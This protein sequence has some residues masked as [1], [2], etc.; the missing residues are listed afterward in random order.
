MKHIKHSSS[1][2]KY[3]NLQTTVHIQRK[4]PFV[5]A[6]K[7]VSKQL[8]QLSAKQPNVSYITV[9]GMGAAIEKTMALGVHFQAQG[10]VD[11]LTKTITVMDEFEEDDDSTF[12]KRVISGVEL[13]VYK[14]TDMN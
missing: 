12:K 11:V 7:R 4:T 5:S 13:H 10:K 9:L 3:S 2:F 14:P 6:L 1:Q 8:S